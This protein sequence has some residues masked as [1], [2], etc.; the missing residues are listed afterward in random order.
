ME[1]TISKKIQNEKEDI[2]YLLYEEYIQKNQ[3][4]QEGTLEESS[5]KVDQKVYQ[6]IF[7]KK[8]K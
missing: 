1:K 4:H 5:Y 2:K 8:Y 3:E 6:N 7:D